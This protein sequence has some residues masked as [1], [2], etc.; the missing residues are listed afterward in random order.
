[1]RRE[2]SRVLLVHA[3]EVAWI[4]EQYAHLDDVIEARAAG[5]QNGLAV[6][7]SLSC[8]DL[9]GFASQVAR[10]PVRVSMPVVPESNT[11]DPALTAWLYS[12]ELGTSLTSRQEDRL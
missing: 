2:P 3:G 7:Q 12:G 11:C 4:G 9:D 8:L 1:M 10:S 5:L 6:G